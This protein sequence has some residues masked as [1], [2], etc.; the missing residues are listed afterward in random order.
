T[1]YSSFGMASITVPAD[2]IEQACA[3][4]LGAEVVDHWGRLSNSEFNAASLTEIVLTD[5]LPSIRLLEGNQ[6]VQGAI[7]QRHD[8]QNALLDD[9]RKQGQKI[10]N[11]ITQAV[12]QIAREVRDGIHK[13]K[14]QNLSQYLRAGVER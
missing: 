4:K 6:P 10:Q 13:Q 9:G 3:Y 7:E 2:R 12:G 5:I 1:R 11:L 14:G 8:L